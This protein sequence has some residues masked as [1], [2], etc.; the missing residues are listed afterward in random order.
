MDLMTG[1]A[2]ATKALEALKAVREIDKSYDDATWKAKVAE[3]MVSV[4]DMKLALIDAND[5]IR[6]LENDKRELTNKL[7]FKAEKTIYKN[8][9]LYEVF[10][11]GGVAEFPFCQRCLTEAKYIRLARPSMSGGIAMCPGCKATFDL[12]SVMHRG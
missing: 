5:T 10:E 6:A 3:L 11:G 12:R 4:A 1:I 9:C 2:A 8:G 7:T